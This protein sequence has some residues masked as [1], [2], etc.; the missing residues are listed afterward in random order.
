MEVRELVNTALLLHDYQYNGFD[1]DFSKYRNK[2]EVLYDILLVSKTILSRV[3]EWFKEE[4]DVDL[5]KVY[6]IAYS[7]V[8]KLEESK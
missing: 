5:D 4:W 1:P 3:K 7:D 6:E 8:M 2:V